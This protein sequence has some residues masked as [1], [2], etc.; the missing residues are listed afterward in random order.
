MTEEEFF[1]ST[2]KKLFKLADIHLEL[3]SPHEV[4]KKDGK[5]EKYIDNI[6][7]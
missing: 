4:E 3:N 5:E 7:F 6:N 2:P 1:K